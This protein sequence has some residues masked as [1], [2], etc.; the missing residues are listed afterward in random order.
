MTMRCVQIE[1][2]RGP[3]LS[4][5]IHIYMHA[6]IH[7]YVYTYTYTTI[8]NDDVSLIYIHAYMYNDDVLLSGQRAHGPQRANLPSLFTQYIHTYKK[9]MCAYIH[10]YIHTCIMTM[11]SFQVKELMARKGQPSLFTGEDEVDN[12]PLKCRMCDAVSATCLC[13]CVYVC[14]QPSLFTWEDEVDNTP[15]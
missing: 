12:T 3:P 10:I 11:Y 1:G 14:I 8:Y 6:Y 7:T 9:Y 5:Y 2:L 13:V 4:A 15:V